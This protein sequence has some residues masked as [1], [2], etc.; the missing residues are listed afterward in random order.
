M[1]RL[2]MNELNDLDGQNQDNS[3][4]IFDCFLREMVVE[5]MSKAAKMV[6]VES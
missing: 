3:N 6:L 2:K 1:I 4:S 5:S